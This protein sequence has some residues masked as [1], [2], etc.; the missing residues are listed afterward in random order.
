MQSTGSTGRGGLSTVGDGAGMRVLVVTPTFPWPLDM[1]NRVRI[2]NLI[3]EMARRH[4]VEMVAM[5]SPGQA[6]QVTRAGLDHYFN[7]GVGMQVVPRAN[8]GLMRRGVLKGGQIYADACHGVPEQEFY[9]GLPRFTSTVKQALCS[10]RFDVAVVNYWFTAT[11]AIRSSPIPVVCDTHDVIVEQAARQAYPGLGTLA[12]A[13]RRSRRLARMARREA[14]QLEAMD[15]LI[16]VHDKDRQTISS[17]L[18]VRTP[19]T[20]IAHVPDDSRFSFVEPHHRPPVVLFYGALQSPM[21]QAAVRVF[22]SKAWP[23]IATSLPGAEFWL[24]GSHMDA[25]LRRLVASVPG[26][27]AIG[28]TGDIDSLLKRVSVAVLPLVSGAGLKGRVLECMAAGTPVVGT[29]IAFE[30]LDVRDGEHVLCRSSWSSFAD[31][32]TSLALDRCLRVRLATN[33]RAWLRA[34]YSWEAQYGRVHEVLE[35]AVMRHRNR[36]AN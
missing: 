28:F 29:P 30:G 5:L 36:D 33:S 17:V 11:R 6:D 14:H 8:R 7:L 12:D 13:L 20:S 27:S 35:S 10:G 1:G 24:A 19:S 4:R 31:A 18:G 26:G 9:Y 32:V 15:W 21:N 34:N 23:Q 25:E 16:C 2:H 22:L 3:R